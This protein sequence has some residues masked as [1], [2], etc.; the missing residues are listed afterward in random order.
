[1][2]T[3][4]KQYNEFNENYSD[5]RDA[6]DYIC[7]QDF[8]QMLNI[9]ISGKRALDVGCGNGDDVQILNSKGAV[10]S[11]IEPSI[12][13]VHEG[14]EKGLDIHHGI[15]EALPF[16]EETFDLV[17]SKYA[18]QTS[19]KAKECMLEAGRV[20]KPEGILHVLIKHPL[21]QFIEKKKFLNKPIN[22]FKQE[23]TK[24]VIYDG[25]I[26]LKEPTHTME[27]YLNADFFKIFDLIDYRENFDFP[28]SEQ[29][30]GDIYPTYFVLTARKK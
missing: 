28:A 14:T 25:L 26:T 15:G 27:D 18:I 2:K 4:D 20:L 9:N 19:T 3:T 23:V 11:G 12:D 29:I 24:S 16:K 30:D 21:R 5:N 7:D 6:H 17:I 1:M 13:F 10:A 8:Y 22:Y